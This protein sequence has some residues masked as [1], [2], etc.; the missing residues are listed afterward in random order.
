MATPNIVRGQIAIDPTNDLLYYINE[1]NTLVSTSLSW[2][3]SNSAIQTAENV[4]IDGDLTVSG[5][6]VTVNAETLLIEDNIIV[7][8]TGTTGSPSLNAGIEVERGT[9]NNVQI[10]WNESTDKWQFS[11]DGTTFYNISGEGADISANVTGNLIGNVTGNADTAT[12]LST[13]RKIELTGPVTGFAMFD[14][15]SNVSISTSLTSESTSLNS[16]SDVTAPSPSSGDFL[17]YDGSAWVNDVVDLGTDTNGNY[18][19][20]LSAG[21]GIQITNASGEGVTPTISVNTSVVQT[22]VTNVSDI[23]IGY[24]DGVTSS[25]QNQLNSKAPTSS[26]T[27]TGTVSGITKVMVGLGNI[28]N[29]ADLDKPVSNAQQTA[30]NLK[31]NIAS[32]TFTGNVNIPTLFV[33]SIEIDPTGAT[34]GKVL[35]FNSSLGKFIPAEDSVATAGSLN[36]NDL[37]D[38]DVSNLASGQILKYNGSAWINDTDNAGITI[39]YLDDISDVNVSSKSTNDLLKWDGNSW[40]AVTPTKSMVGLNNVDNTTDLNKPIS[41]A[42][43]TALNL[44]ANSNISPTITLSGDL[45]GNVT[46]TNLGSATLT[47]TISANSVALGSDTTGDYVSSLISGNGILISNNSGEGSTPTIAANTSYLAT[48]DY[49]DSS[50]SGVNWH[51]AVKAATVGNLAGTYNNGTNGVGATLTNATNGSIGTIDGASVVTNDRILVKAQTDAKQNGIYRIVTP[52]NSTTAWQLMRTSDFD[53][54]S[55][56]ATIIPGDS[57]F[58]TS[59]STNANQGFIQTTYGTGANSSII[60]NTDNITFT[61]FTGTA[62]LTAGNGLTITG[63][64]LDVGTAS[65]SRIVVNADNIDL[66]TTGV[67]ANTY[68]SVTVDTYGRITAGTNPTTLSGYG[69]TDAV[70]SSL[71]S[72]YIVLGNSGGVATGTA[73]SGDVTIASN[74]NVQIASNTIVNAD[75]NSA[76]AIVYSKLS[77]SNS[78][79]N[80]DI[81]SSAAIAYSK[82]SLSNSIVNADISSTAAITYSKLSLANSITTT[83]LQVG[84]AKGGFNS[85]MRTVAASNTLVAGDLAKLIRVN[86]SSTI[87]ITVPNILSD[88]DRIDL[89]REGTGE[90]TIV[91]DTGVNVYGTPGLKLR[92]R[93]SGATLVKLATNTWVAFGDLKQ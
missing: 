29:T 35:K 63:N 5:T 74:G 46:L 33:D 86:S 60:I 72:G 4:V 38:V 53:G 50:V 80:A 34:D 67:S 16:L 81:N 13:S 19:A 92:D 70:S 61:Q 32:P 21:T 83:D 64:Q 37:A 15:S 36:I 44:K 49:V 87:N 30:L 10:R 48:K 71:T 7:L 9:S 51:S 45:S 66:A 22:R 31:A 27:F 42:T 91:G 47:A 58:V 11:N 6:T 78:V 77:L 89:L 54:S 56:S 93:W 25:V 62:S 69:I 52:G 73:I 12:K 23:E 76:A 59:G 39:N 75:I 82:L 26:P 65:S 79:V 8:N 88:G 40:T 17:K 84:P 24:L 90:V 85:V 41:N 18:V 55:V 28:D 3:K 68:K 20:N 57:V 14:G 43:Q 2:A 1:S